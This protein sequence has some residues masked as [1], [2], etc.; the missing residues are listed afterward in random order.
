MNEIAR[1][2]YEVR[3]HWWAEVMF[4]AKFATIV[5]TQRLLT[6][7]DK[8]LPPCSHEDWI[9]VYD[10]RLQPWWIAPP[11]ARLCRTCGDTF[12]LPKLGTY[13]VWLSW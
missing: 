5:S 2:T 11:I 9:G 8:L 3:V 6:S 10:Y 13:E 12:P 7:G 4:A 1:F